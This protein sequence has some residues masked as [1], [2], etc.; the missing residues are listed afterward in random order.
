MLRLF[1]RAAGTVALIALAVSI[2]PAY[3]AAF[4]VL[5]LIEPDLKQPVGTDG[6]Y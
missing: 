2:L 5:G 3:Y 6:D 1:K 4:A